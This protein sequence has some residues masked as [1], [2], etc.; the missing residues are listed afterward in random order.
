MNKSKHVKTYISTNKEPNIK[1]IGNAYN[2]IE[3]IEKDLCR[4]QEGIK[5]LTNWEAI[6]T[7][8]LNAKLAESII[9]MAKE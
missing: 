3:N 5:D 9:D 8:I 6:L 2:N 4:V 1:L 7:I